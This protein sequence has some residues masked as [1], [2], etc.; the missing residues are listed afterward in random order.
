VPIIEGLSGQE[1]IVVNAGA[2]LNPGETIRPVK[3][4][5]AN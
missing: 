1:M 4:K 2:F 5:P 3:A